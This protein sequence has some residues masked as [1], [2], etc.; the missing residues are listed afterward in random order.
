MIG[1]REHTKNSIIW[2]KWIIYEELGNFVLVLDH[3]RNHKHT[4]TKSSCLIYSIC[5]SYF[6]SLILTE[7]R[8]LFFFLTCLKKKKRYYPNLKPTLYVFTKSSIDL[9]WSWCR[10]FICLV[11]TFKV[12]QNLASLQY[13]VSFTFAPPRRKCSV[14]LLLMAR[15]IRRA[16]VNT[17]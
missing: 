10:S 7:L 2:V 16:V 4:K 15:R 6:F 5:P 9:L 17:I 14:S 8:L 11:L 3:W 1:D 13:P 12:V